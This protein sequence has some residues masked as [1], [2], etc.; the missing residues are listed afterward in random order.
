MTNNNQSDMAKTRENLKSDAI[1]VLHVLTLVGANGEYGG[2]VKVARELCEEL[3][4]A[5][6]TPKIIAGVHEHDTKLGDS[7]IP[8]TRVLVRPLVAALPFSSLWGRSVLRELHKSPIRKLE[9]TT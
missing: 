9:S 1:S 3:A 5:G 4:R 2:P 8:F 6:N 7:A